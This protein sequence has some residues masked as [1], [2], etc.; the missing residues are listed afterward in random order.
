MRIFTTFSLLFTFLFSFFGTTVFA[1]N[2]Q[3]D[4]RFT[5]KNFDCA[6][7]KVIVQVQ[8]KAHDEAHSFLM[9][10][11]SYFFDYD[12]SVCRNPQLISQE[13]FSNQAPANDANYFPQILTEPRFGTLSLNTAY[14][15]GG[16]GAKWVNATWVTVACIRFD[17]Q[18]ATKCLMLTWHDDTRVPITGIIVPRQHQTFRR[19]LNVKTD[20]GNRCPSRANPLRA[21][22]TVSVGRA[23]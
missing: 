21:I 2:G 22:A 18:D 9:G 6:N 8:I 15:N 16:Y 20:T 1:Q 3:F 19:I 13:R 23:E 17:V 5:A 11:A 7:N 14:A 10:D 12:P 4:V